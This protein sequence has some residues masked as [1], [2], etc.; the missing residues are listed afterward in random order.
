MPRP[1]QTLLD[2][3]S[4][5]PEFRL[6]TNPFA[7]LAPGGVAKFDYLAGSLAPH[8]HSGDLASYFDHYDWK[9]KDRLVGVG[10]T[11]LTTLAPPGAAAGTVILLSG[12]QGTGRKSLR[13]M[14]HY[15][16][17]SRFAPRPVIV[18]EHTAAIVPDRLN[19]ADTLL[20]S[21]FRRVRDYDDTLK[22]KGANRLSKLMADTRKEWK[23]SALVQSPDVDALFGYL[24]EDVSRAATV[25]LI[26]FFLDATV[27]AFDLDAWRPTCATL[28]KL[29]DYAFV[30]FSDLSKAS[31]LK[32]NLATNAIRVA[33]VDSPRITKAQTVD[34]LR[35]R[36]AEERTPALAAGAGSEPELAPF[37]G[38]ALDE[39]FAPTPRAPE[40]VTLPI[41]VVI[42]RLDGAFSQKCEA[43]AQQLAAN[44]GNV[45][46]IPPG[47][48]RITRDDMKRLIP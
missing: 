33:L 40:P 46:A 8:Q 43:L 17:H 23:E 45:N 32:Y 21:F 37:T 24:K 47:A 48:V 3:L 9:D 29:A 16:V 2:V 34:F 41:K 30:S 39:L 22:N 26:V 31:I 11:G 28:C 6:R 20:Q 12:F 13:N 44:G 1:A 19:V 7:P 14:L 36:L 27:H 42:S 10:K 18:T 5:H 15:D 38:A 35:W 4:A 25:P